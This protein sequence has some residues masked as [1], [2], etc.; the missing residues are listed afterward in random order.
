MIVRDEKLSEILS[1]IYNSDNFHL[2]FGNTI[3]NDVFFNEQ[4]SDARIEMGIEFSEIGKLS[5]VVKSL[6]EC[7][8]QSF[9]CFDIG[10][11]EVLGEPIEVSGGTRCKN[12]VHC[13]MDCFAA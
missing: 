7:F 9:A 1:S 5:E 13:E 8:E 11:Q 2:N 12:E 3:K 10:F 4:A 6:V